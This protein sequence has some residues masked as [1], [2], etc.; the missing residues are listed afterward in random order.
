MDTTAQRN[1]TLTSD[2]VKAPRMEMLMPFQEDHA[3]KIVVIVPEVYGVPPAINQVG[4]TSRLI[5]LQ[6]SSDWAPLEFSTSQEWCSIPKIRIRGW[7]DIQVAISTS[8]ISYPRVLKELHGSPTGGHFGVMKTLHRVR[9]RFCWGKCSTGYRDMSTSSTSFRSGKKFRLCGIEVCELLGID[10]TK[11][12]PLHPQSD[13]MVERFNRT[14]LNNLSLMVSKNQQDW[15]QKVPLFSAS[16]PQR[17]S[18]D[19]RIF[20]IP[21]A[22]WPR[23]SS[24]L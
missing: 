15:D 23:S 18:R 4:R 20:T 19:Y 16:V 11:T 3:Q 5:V 22:F 17:R 21:D 24:P 8:S 7:K 1:I 12:T 10:K 14:I 6:L 9:E 2:I 13:G